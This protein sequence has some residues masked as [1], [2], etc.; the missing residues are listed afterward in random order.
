MP[1]NKLLVLAAGQI[2]EAPRQKVEFVLAEN[3]VYLALLD[4]HSLRT[5][6]KLK[7]LA[8]QAASQ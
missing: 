5:R 3:R 8:F 1:W 2:D 6:Q 4:R 7:R